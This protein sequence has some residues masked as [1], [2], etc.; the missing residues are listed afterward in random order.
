MYN[1]CFVCGNRIKYSEDKI[2]FG[3]DGD[4][5]HKKCKS[6]I[7]KKYD[8]LNNMTDREFSIYLRGKDG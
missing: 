6:D 3:C 8:E 2:L 7:S 4:F 1:T 5:I